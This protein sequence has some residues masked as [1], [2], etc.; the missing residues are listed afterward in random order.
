MLIKIKIHVWNVFGNMSSHY[1]WP[2]I[3]LV[4]MIK[5]I[6]DIKHKFK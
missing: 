2:Y 5:E 1:K 3:F 4:K 6:S